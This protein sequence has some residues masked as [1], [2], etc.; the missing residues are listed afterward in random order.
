MLKRY[1]QLRVWNI[2]MGIFHLVQ[3]VAVYILSN[4]FTLPLDTNYVEFNQ[5]TFSLEP[6]RDTVM[7]LKIGPL[8]ALFL[9][10]SALAHFTISLPGVYQWYVENLKKKIN[11][12]RW[13]E[14]SFSASLMIV[15]IAML[16]GVYDMSTLILMFGINAGMILFGLMMELHNQSTKKVNWTSFFFGCIMGILPW[17]VI[18]LNLFNAGEGDNKAPDFVYYIF[19]S[20]FLFFNTFAVNQFLQYKKVGKWRD[21]LF[22]EKMYIIL[23]LLAKSILAWQVFAGTLRPV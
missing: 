21:Y 19:L 18:G 23:S 16:T 17:V 3:S 1:K 13:Y 4:D 9:L 20:I 10:F 6:V 7:D 8:V 22:G 12:A 15:L 2:V 14:Y 5:S 11:L